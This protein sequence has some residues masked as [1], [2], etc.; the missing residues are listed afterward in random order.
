MDL[1]KRIA[2]LEE[3]AYAGSVTLP[4]GTEFNP[5]RCFKLM[6]TA[7]RIERDCHSEPQSSD[8]TEEE[9]QLWKKFATLPE[10]A[11]ISPLMEMTC[12]IAKRLC[13]DN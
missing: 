10:P 12:Q 5:T 13:Y 2:R 1:S 6:R 8:F 7:L 9:W 3:K 4:D 11:K